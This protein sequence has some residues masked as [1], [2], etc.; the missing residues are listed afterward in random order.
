MSYDATRLFVS[1]RQ[2]RVNLIAYVVGPAQGIRVKGQG[3]EHVFTQKLVSQLQALPTLFS[4]HLPRTVTPISTPE[5][6][7]LRSP[8]SMFFYLS[9][10]L[11]IYL[12]FYL[13]I[14][15]YIYICLKCV[16]VYIYRV[17]TYR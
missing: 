4:E 9:I 1:V 3:L 16:C 17:Y 13:S 15:I 11:S 12:S 10:Y 6:S 7:G 14:Y 8:N 5:D 2:S